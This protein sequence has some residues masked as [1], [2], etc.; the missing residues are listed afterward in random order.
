[1]KIPGLKS[2]KRHPF[3]YLSFIGGFLLFVHPFAYLIQL[4]DYFQGN[5]APST[6]HAACFR[7]SIDWIASGK[8]MTLL[9]RPFTAIFALGVIGTAFF[10]GPLFC[11]WVCPVGSCTECL[12]RPVPKKMQIDLSKKISPAALR[13]GF[14]GAFLVISTFLV[15]NSTT[16]IVGDCCTAVVQAAQ[17]TQGAAPV[18]VSTTKSLGENF[19]LSSICCR[20]CAS[21]QLQNIV[22]GVFTP[23]TLEFWNSASIMVMGAWLMIGGL[24]WKGGRGWCLYGCPLGAVSNV[25]HFIGSKLPFTGRINYDGEKCTGCNRCRDICPT[26]SIT[27]EAKELS[28]SRHTCNTCLECVKICP[29]K[30]FTYGKKNDAG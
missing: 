28:V 15:F 19:G 10:F 16:P 18:A 17:S 6:I 12:S 29:Q 26:W 9:G 27:G 24:F 13:Y 8:I 3:R 4:A 14:L 7:M 2:I 22:D 5:T 21:T 23:S 1:M 25:S 20:Y 30:C 11:G